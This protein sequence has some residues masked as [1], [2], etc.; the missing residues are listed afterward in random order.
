MKK[1]SRSQSKIPNLKEI[2]VFKDVDIE[3]LRHNQI[4]KQFIILFPNLKYNNKNRS[5]ENI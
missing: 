5:I 3:I 4:S 2:Q 1:G